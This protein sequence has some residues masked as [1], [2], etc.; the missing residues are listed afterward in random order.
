MKPKGQA[1][2]EKDHPKKTR[3]LTDMPRSQ[4][5]PK[6]SIAKEKSFLNPKIRKMK[7]C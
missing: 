1:A 4:E 2:P 5:A 3:G 7:G 6:G